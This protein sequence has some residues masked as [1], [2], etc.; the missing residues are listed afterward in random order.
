M[1]KWET[2]I[3]SS[4]IRYGLDLWELRNREIHGQTEQ[5]NRHIQRQKVL[6]ITRDLYIQGETSVPIQQRQLFSLHPIRRLKH[7]TKQLHRW[8]TLVLLAQTLRQ[9]EID[10]DKKLTCQLDRFGFLMQPPKVLSIPK[11]KIQRRIQQDMRRF[12][13]NS[14]PSVRYRSP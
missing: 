9:K 7:S 6:T 4:L 14:N 12:L 3:V 5:E 11:I 13:L 2:H 10:E 1:E 8:N